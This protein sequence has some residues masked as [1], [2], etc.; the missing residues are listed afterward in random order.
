MAR[1]PVWVAMALVLLAG[2][3]AR[4]QGAPAE[5]PPTPLEFWHVGDDALSERLADEVDTALAHSAE[6]VPSRGKKPGSLLVELPANVVA[7]RVGKRARVSYTVNYSTADGHAI[8]SAS[9]SCWDHQLD[10]CADQIVKHAQIAARK[11]K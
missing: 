8:G 11:L 3:S 9:G 6:F 2:A 4:G 1:Y 10:M 7:K 5:K